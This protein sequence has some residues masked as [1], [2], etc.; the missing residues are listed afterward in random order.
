MINFFVPW[1]ISTPDLSFN[2]LAK[3][4]HQIFNLTS[5]PVLRKNRRGASATKTVYSCKEFP[6]ELD[7]AIRQFFSIYLQ[8]LFV[9]K[10]HREA[11]L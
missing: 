3:A 8:N 5:K 10:D 7:K 6:K 9:R 4:I 11:V 1:I 2:Y